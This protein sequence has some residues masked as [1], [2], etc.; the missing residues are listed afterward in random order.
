MSAAR[1]EFMDSFNLQM[2]A[3][4]QFFFLGVLSNPEVLKKAQAEVDR[5]LPA[6]TLPDIADEAS[7][8][9]VTAIVRECFR[10]KVV[11]PFGWCRQVMFEKG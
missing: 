11:T 8:P 10:W 7:L 6:G 1:A 2:I 9:Y 4:M 5:V 3:A